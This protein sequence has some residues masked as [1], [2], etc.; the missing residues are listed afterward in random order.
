MS[1]QH[2]PRRFAGAS[3]RLVRKQNRLL[4]KL[5][6]ALFVLFMVAIYV[7][8]PL[9]LTRSFV[10]P[11][12]FV[13]LVLMPIIALM[14]HRRI[15][16]YEAAFVG[17]IFLVLLL[18]VL[19]SPGFGYID[20]KLLGLAQAVVAI[21]GGVLLLKLLNDLQK[22]WVARVL[23]AL[24]VV[25]VA[26]AFLEVFGVLGTVSDSFR[27]VAFKQIGFRVLYEADERDIALI[28]GF[29]RPKF[30]TAE[31]SYL[32]IGFFA[33]INSW[34]ILAY[35]RKS[36]F[37][38]CLGT[39][40]MF[41]L[42]GSPVLALSLAVSLI[43]VLYNEPGLASLVFISVLV[44]IVGLG[45][46]YAQPQVFTN[47]L[48]RVSESYENLGTSTSS[49]EN[50]RL[51]FPY[52]TLVDVIR[53]APLF[54]V[55]IAG[56]E[57][58]ERYSSLPVAPAYALGNNALAWFFIYF[59]LVG[60]FLF[61]KFTFDYWRRAKVGRIALLVVLVF[62]LSQTMGGPE[63]IKFWGYVFLFAG[64]VKKSSAPDE[65][66]LKATGNKRVPGYNDYKLLRRAKRW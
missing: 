56:K 8:V 19:L 29:P 52:I 13:L 32:A 63:T 11:N 34:L 24:S 36:L 46:A 22:R 1:V 41:G 64:V 50:R 57:V 44:C 6:I 54:G 23:L 30:F 5:R 15:Y 31:P 61:I 21:T 49:S 26:G 14:Y 65:R 66:A 16:K 60:S 3:S 4:P 17:K 27:E 37:V 47:F 9:F 25:L 59:G 58:I 38:A 20:Q 10:I 45:L 33:F 42:T 62:A 48:E 40:V 7:D 18:S 55:G 28:T 51:L 53:E 35:S 43:I 2:S 12:V 39:L